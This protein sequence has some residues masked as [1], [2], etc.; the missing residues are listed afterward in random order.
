M[1]IYKMEFKGFYLGGTIIV[2][3]ESEGKAKQIAESFIYNNMGKEVP[4][5]EIEKIKRNEE[6]IYFYDGDY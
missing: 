5:D 2:K 1:N 4:I 6:I 3:A